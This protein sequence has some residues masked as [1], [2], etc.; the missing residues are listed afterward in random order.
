MSDDSTKPKVVIVTKLVVG[1]AVVVE[2]VASVVEV[3]TVVGVTRAELGS[4][5]DVQAADTS[6]NPIARVSNFMSLSM[7]SP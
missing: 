1:V 2:V 3:V 5:E 7:A 6:V 4:V